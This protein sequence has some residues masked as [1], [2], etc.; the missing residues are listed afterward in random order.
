MLLQEVDS[1]Y[2]IKQEYNYNELYVP[3][4]IVTLLYV[5]STVL[6]E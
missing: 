3:D 1:D 5:D 4:Q 2:E 6:I